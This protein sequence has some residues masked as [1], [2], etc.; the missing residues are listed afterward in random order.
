MVG[1]VMRALEP[2]VDSAVSAVGGVVTKVDAFGIEVEVDGGSPADVEA[3]IDEAVG[4]SIMDVVHK[5][6]HPF[7]TDQGLIR[8]GVYSP[9]VP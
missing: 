8:G 9:P 3:A 4:S 2:V 1:R 5:A 6:P 7:F